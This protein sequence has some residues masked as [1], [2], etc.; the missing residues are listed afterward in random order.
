MNQESD[1]IHHYI[2]INLSQMFLTGI[3]LYKSENF[4]I[5]KGKLKGNESNEHE[6][7]RNI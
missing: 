7:L 3:T 5:K 6:L 2:L 4:K 1:I